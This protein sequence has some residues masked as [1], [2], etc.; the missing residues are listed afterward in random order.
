MICLRSL[1]P[2]SFGF[3]LAT[4]VAPIGSHAQKGKQDKPNIIF[5]LADDLGIGNISAYGAD[6]FSSPNIDALAKSGILFNHGY[7][8]PLCGPSRALLMTGRYA[9][10]TGAVNQDKT[11]DMLPSVETMI[12]N[13]IKP[14]GYV[15]ACIGKWGQ[16][17]LG[18]SE[19][20]FDDYLRFK[21]SGVYW[22]GQ[23][24][25]TAYNENGT[26]KELSATQYMPDLM[27]EH[28]VEFLGKNKDKPFFVYYPMS[29]VHAKLVPTPDSKPDTKDIYA[30]NIAYMDKLVGKLVKALDSLK[31]RQNTVLIFMGD[32]G[33]GNEAAPRS[34]I[35]GKKLVGK[36]GSL[37][38]CGS[39]VPLIV[40]WP[41]K[42][43][44]GSVEQSLVDGSDFMPTFAELAGAKMPTALP[45]D[46]HSFAPLLT[47][48]KFT[49]REW[50]FMELGNGWYVRDNKWKL[51]RT[52]QLFDMSNAPFEEKEVT[53]SDND[54]ANNA[55][56]RLQATLDMLNPASGIMDDGDGN[57]RH[58]K[59][60]KMIHEKKKDKE[61]KEGKEKKKDKEGG[62]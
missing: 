41:A 48:K 17:P 7:T 24:K 9:F 28:L 26:E 1:L 14:A 33:T 25:A 2:L 22:G 19:F 62:E 15:T 20:G 43:K 56:K 42:I 50:M 32:N 8:A 11:G 29:H 31:L 51:N 13:V 52:N 10:R 45:Y 4:L 59:K 38:E 12:P 27:H 58:A 61:G 16:L 30:D 3:L 34:T 57:G 23:G 54:E 18:P 60:N 6:N 40:S 39:L 49:P 55:R 36:K 37:E 21:G 47:G 44:K 5:V 35:H 53:A 46:G